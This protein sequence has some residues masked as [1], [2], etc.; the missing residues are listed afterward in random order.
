MVVDI[1]HHELVSCAQEAKKE[2]ENGG[3]SD[4]DAASEVAGLHSSP[5]RSRLLV[6]SLFSY[7]HIASGLRMP[8]Y[9]RG[10]AGNI[11][12]AASEKERIASDPEAQLSTAEEPLSNPPPSTSQDEQAYKRSGRGGAGNF[13]TPSDE[14]K[15]PIQAAEI[16]AASKPLVSPA[17]APAKY[18]RGGAGNINFATG[19]KDERDE[20]VKSEEL[21]MQ[22]MVAK[23]VEDFVEEGLQVPEKARLHGT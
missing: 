19:E 9:G 18:G 1:K 6:R 14:A 3:K 15:L 12:A 8:Y 16:D 7:T 4:S 5:P 22:E 20:K 11:Q 13:F 23:A 17:S 2:K 21:K 10:G